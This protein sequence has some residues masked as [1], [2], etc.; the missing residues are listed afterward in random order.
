MYS[1]WCSAV[2]S[3]MLYLEQ[4]NL[5]TICSEISIFQYSTTHFHR[6]VPAWLSNLTFYS[7]VISSLITML[8]CSNKFQF[9]KFLTFKVPNLTLH[10]SSNQ[11]KVGSISV[12]SHTTQNHFKLKYTSQY[13]RVILSSRK[14]HFKTISLRPITI[15]SM[16]C[17]GQTIFLW[18]Y[19]IY[20]SGNGDR[21]FFFRKY[22]I[23]YWKAGKAID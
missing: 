18:I 20:R 6:Y 1:Y 22:Y 16:G 4:N 14:Q 23:I 15:K 17:Y 12:C 10:H 8:C 21:F 5:L 7:T 19:N 11:S 3:F 2:Y 9:D 13:R